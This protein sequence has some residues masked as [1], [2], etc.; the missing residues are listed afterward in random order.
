MNARERRSGEQHLEGRRLDQHREPAVEQPL[1][2]ELLRERPEGIERKEHQDGWL[3]DGTPLH[4][5][6]RHQPGTHNR[7]T[8]TD[9]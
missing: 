9:R 8:G 6:E 4:H 3:P 2:G 1:K 7:G 5:G